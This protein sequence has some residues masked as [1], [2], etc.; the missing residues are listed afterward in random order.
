MNSTGSDSAA[1]DKQMFGHSS[2]SVP[3]FTRTFLY[4]APVFLTAANLEK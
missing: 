1:P 2:L 4:F 3:G